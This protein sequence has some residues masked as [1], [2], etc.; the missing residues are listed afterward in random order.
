[1]CFKASEARK[2]SKK[3]AKKKSNDKFAVGTAKTAIF[4]GLEDF[5]KGLEDLGL[6][7]PPVWESMKQ[8]HCHRA[9]SHEEFNVCFAPYLLSAILAVCHYALSS[10]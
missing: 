7:N 5:H 2:Q 4:G 10:C 9:D 8:E 3:T 6:P 1:V